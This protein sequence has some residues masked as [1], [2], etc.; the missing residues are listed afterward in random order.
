MKAFLK[1]TARRY[2]GHR[3]PRSAAELAYYLLF[4]VL[5]TLIFLSLLLGRLSISR[6][7][8][9]DRL[10]FLVPEKVVSLI[11]DYLDY[12]G[13]ATESNRVFFMFA[14]SVLAVYMIF[15]ALTSL[16]YAVRRALNVQL[17]QNAAK[18]A[19]TLLFALILLG[20]FAAVLTLLSISRGVYR[21]ISE[22]LATDLHTAVNVIRF[23]AGPALIFVVLWMYYF[24]ISDKKYK[25]KGCI[26]GAA[27]AAAFIY[28]FSMLFAVYFNKFADI[29]LLYGSLGSIILLLL[30][31]HMI[32]TGLI[33]GAEIMAV[34]KGEEF[35]KNP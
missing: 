4:A 22:A 11:G 34:I 35:K 23:A 8:F 20:L 14:G 32:G 29:G 17:A 1:E 9:F 31:L 12:A 21:I 27:V 19:V 25:L 6:T 30:W 33:M 24:F 2:S 18:T 16:N 15:R 26:C 7:E 5:P 10:T 3:V 28:G 13:S